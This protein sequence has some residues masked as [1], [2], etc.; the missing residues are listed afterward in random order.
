MLTTMIRYLLMR[1]GVPV[2]PE[3]HPFWQG[4]WS[5]RAMLAR[6]LAGYY[7]RLAGE[8]WPRR[9]RISSSSNLGRS[10]DVAL[11]LT[12]RG[13]CYNNRPF[14][15]VLFCFVVFCFVLLSFVLFCILFSSFLLIFV[16]LEDSLHDFLLLSLCT[17]LDHADLQWSITAVQL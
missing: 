4:K 5:F 8:L 17:L 11:P 2:W 6:M 15:F 10:E 7:D 14:C 9:K 3:L 13:G 1:V 12:G 16:S